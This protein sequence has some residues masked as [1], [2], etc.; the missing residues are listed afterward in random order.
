MS[1]ICDRCSEEK[2]NRDVMM[3]GD[4]A[5]CCTCVSDIIHSIP[6]NRLES[7]CQAERERRTVVL[8]CALGTEVLEDGNPNYVTRFEEVGMRVQCNED[9]E[10][11]TMD[12]VR[13]MVAA[14]RS[15][16]ATHP[17]AE[18]EAAMNGGA[19]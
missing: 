9:S 15:E 14:C 4:K 19:E 13:D 12:E 10:W 16:T 18:A 3:S 11:F 8:P 7:L 2:A 5:V 17:E 1:W 6:I